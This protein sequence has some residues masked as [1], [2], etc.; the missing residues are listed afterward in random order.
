MKQLKGTYYIKYKRLYFQKILPNS[1][2]LSY[3]KVTRWCHNVFLQNSQT[4]SMWWSYGHEQACWKS[5]KAGH[6]NP[7]FISLQNAITMEIHDRY[8]SW[9]P[10]LY[11]VHIAFQTDLTHGSHHAPLI[12]TTG[13]SS[14]F[15]PSH[16]LFPPKEKGGCLSSPHPS[17]FPAQ[18]QQHFHPQLRGLFPT[19][20]T[21]WNLQW[22]KLNT[23]FLIPFLINLFACMS[24]MIQLCIAN[25]ECPTLPCPSCWWSRATC[26]HHWPCRGCL[27]GHRNWAIASGHPTSSGWRH[28]G[29]IPAHSW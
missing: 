4:F 21:S 27:G 16:H 20:I 23:A 5:Y 22:T 9:S 24:V 18:T 8:R 6:L 11:W 25:E 2:T 10:L 29:N 28:Q 13:F 19:Q 15:L 12:T 7:A 17:A 3:T 1:A 14:A 26:D